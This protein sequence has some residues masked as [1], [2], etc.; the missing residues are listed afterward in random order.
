VPAFHSIRYRLFPF[1]FR[2]LDSSETLPFAFT[3][4][5]VDT[6]LVRRATNGFDPIRLGGCSEN[7]RQSERISFGGDDSCEHDE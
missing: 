3:N 2:P 5:A 4:A 1:P 6:D 7:G